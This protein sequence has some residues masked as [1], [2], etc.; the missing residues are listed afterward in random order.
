MAVKVVQGL[1]GPVASYVDQRPV[2]AASSVA[3]QVSY[4]QRASSSAA[5]QLASHSNSSSEAAVNKIRAHS[6]SRKREPIRS[7]EEV[8][9]LV[10]QVTINLLAEEE[11]AANAHAELTPEEARSYLM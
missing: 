8:F 7:L 6:A 10:E 1:I 2:Q 5:G 11:G 9:G 3:S 4:A